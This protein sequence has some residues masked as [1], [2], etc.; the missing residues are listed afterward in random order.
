VFE[1]AHFWRLDPAQV[2][3]LPISRLELYLAQGERIAALMR[4]E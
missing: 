1:V 2:M 3:A 4:P